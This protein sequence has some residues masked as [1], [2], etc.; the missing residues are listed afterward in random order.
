MIASEGTKLA[1]LFRNLQPLAGG[2]RGLVQS[3]PAVNVINSSR[4]L[5]SGHTVPVKLDNQA[6]SVDL[7]G[8]PDDLSTALVN[9]IGNAL[10][11]IEGD[12]VA[13]PLVTITLQATSQEAI[14]FVDDNGPGVTEEFADSIFDVGFSL[15]PDGTGLGLNIAKEALARSGATLAYHMDF[16][17]GARFEIR[18]PRVQEAA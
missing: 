15:K 18:F 3:F 2:R 8:Y 9:L 16:T 14:I 5:F 7:I 4:E 1:N 13:N 10:H 17:E 12:D 11:W 6:G